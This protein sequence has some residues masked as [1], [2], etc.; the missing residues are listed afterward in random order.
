MI[1]Q[2]I[3]C[4]LA[5]AS[6]AAAG[7]NANA[8]VLI[9][10]VPSTAQV[11]TLAIA[12]ESQESFWVA[13]VVKDVVNFDTYSIRIW[14]DTSS[15]E[16]Q[17][18]LEEDVTGMFGDRKNILHLNGG[19]T[20]GFNV[21]RTRGADTLE[22]IDAIAGESQTQ[23]A[24]GEGLVGLLKFRSRLGA[25]HSAAIRVAYAVLS[26]NLQLWDEFAASTPAGTYSVIEEFAL[27]ISGPHGAT[28]PASEA[29]ALDG[30]PLAIVA[31]PD[32]G[33]RFERWIVTEGA[34]T[35]VDSMDD[36]TTVTLGRGDAAVE[37]VFVAVGAIRGAEGNSAAPGSLR[38]RYIGH[39]NELWFSLPATI[40]AGALKIGLL[41]P[42]GK[43]AGS[44][45]G[46]YS[47]AGYCAVALPSSLPSGLYMCRASAGTARE[48][49]LLGI[50]R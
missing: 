30:I 43:T 7:D 20:E 27:T 42:N 6:V 38:I 3:R 25:D 2:T 9:D 45:R 14:F 32:E 18:A 1:K 13:V 50:Q 26:D 21:R 4:L 10:M 22:L 47:T 28:V 37:A 23:A 31:R 5:L 36:S 44:L 29:R 17:S 15:L 48:S 24:D 8:L 34:A 16:L 11:D 12:G 46:G 41:L 49:F 19:E 40:A 35:F 39:R 33:F